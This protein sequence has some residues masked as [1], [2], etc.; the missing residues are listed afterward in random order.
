MYADQQNATRQSFI[1]NT[2]TIVL[3][4]KSLWNFCRLKYLPAV[5]PDVWEQI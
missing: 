3:S 2:I 1:G 5:D 4:L